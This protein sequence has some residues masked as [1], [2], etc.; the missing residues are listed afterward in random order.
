MAEIADPAVIFTRGPGKPPKYPWDEWLD[1]QARIL[2][3]GVDIS[4]DESWRT[5]RHTARSAAVRKH[6]LIRTRV[7]DQDHFALQAIPEK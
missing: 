4:A 7:I 1:G 5:V 6:S 3:R 2:V